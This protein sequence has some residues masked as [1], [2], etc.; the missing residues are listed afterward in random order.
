MYI[1]SNVITLKKNMAKENI[2]QEF[3]LKNTDEPR[4]YFIGE[5]NQNDLW[6]R[7]TKMFLPL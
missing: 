2:N 1:A 6:V 3:R 4:H 5:I 7:S